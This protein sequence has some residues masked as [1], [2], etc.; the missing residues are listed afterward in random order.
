MTFYCD[1]SDGYGFAFVTVA[2]NGAVSVTGTDPKGASF[3]QIHDI[4]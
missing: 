4:N 1:A 2:S 3:S